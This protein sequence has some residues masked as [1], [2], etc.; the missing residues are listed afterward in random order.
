MTAF[1][2]ISVA[3]SFVIGLAFARLLT[4]AVALVRARRRVRPHWMPL[5]WA[6]MIFLW[7]IQF[8]WAIFELSLIV[9][10]W[11]MWRFTFLLLL[12]LMLFAAAALILPARLDE[13]TETLLQD[14][15]ENGRGGLVVLICYF[16]VGITANIVLFGLSILDPLNILSGTL[17]V[18]PLIV[19]VFRQRF[20][21]TVAT[22][23]NVPLSIFAFLMLSPDVY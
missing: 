15:D 5:V 19:L 23:V 21:Q 7:L 3:L 20:V 10:N 16:L 22:L 17:V 1:E 18:C 8:W 2:F 12:A 4:S 6:T 13:D 11:E 14:F 9:Q